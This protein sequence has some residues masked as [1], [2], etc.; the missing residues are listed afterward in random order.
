MAWGEARRIHTHTDEEVLRTVDE[1]LVHFQCLFTFELL[2]SVFEPEKLL[3]SVDSESKHAHSAS[4]L[5]AT[6]YPERFGGRGALQ[7]TEP[8]L[9]SVVLFPSYQGRRAGVPS[10]LSASWSMRAPQWTICYKGEGFQLSGAAKTLP[11]LPTSPL[12]GRPRSMTE[13]G[14]PACQIEK[15]VHPGGAFSLHP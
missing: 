14:L 6:R 13:E 2:E 8:L 4:S 5:V 1:M 11:R 10:P 7:K 15:L 3:V 12:G 9:S